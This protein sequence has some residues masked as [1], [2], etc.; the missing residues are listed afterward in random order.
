MAVSKSKPRKPEKVIDFTVLSHMDGNPM[1]AAE[2][3]DDE[4]ARG[5]NQYF[6]H[7]VDDASEEDKNRCMVL[8]Y[9]HCRLRTFMARNVPAN[10]GGDETFEVL[11]AEE[12]EGIHMNVGIQ[13][14]AVDESK[15]KQ[16]FAVV[17]V[18]GTKNVGG[19]GVMDG[20]VCELEGDNRGPVDGDI[21]PANGRWIPRWKYVVKTLRARMLHDF[22]RDGAEIQ[23]DPKED[24]EPAATSRGVHNVRIFSPTPEFVSA[25]KM[26]P[27][28]P[29]FYMGIF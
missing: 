8:N 20:E 17:K 19:S 1:T 16:C 26:T 14:T 10:L 28:L 23:R 9:I 29:V 18:G 27:R 4:S 21:D 6:F 24:H 5:S 11:H 13:F 22:Y 2:F 12:F 3:D 25:L 7:P 15:H